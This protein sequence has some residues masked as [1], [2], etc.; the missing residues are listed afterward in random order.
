M[1]LVLTDRI[2][3]V[4]IINNVF[5]LNCWKKLRVLFALNGLLNDA[6]QNCE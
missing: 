2:F 5:E 3:Y 1:S 4:V 6:S